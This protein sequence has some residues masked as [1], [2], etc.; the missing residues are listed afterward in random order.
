MTTTWT[1]P[2]LHLVPCTRQEWREVGRWF[3]TLPDEAFDDG[4]PPRLWQHIIT[5][6]FFDTAKPYSLLI[7]I[8]RRRQQDLIG[9]AFLA[10]QSDQYGKASLFL[11]PPF[12]GRGYGTEALQAL[13]K[14]G[15]SILG[16]RGITGEADAENHAALSVMQKAG[17]NLRY[18]LKTEMPDGS[19]RVI[20]GCTV[21]CEPLKFQPT[22]A[23]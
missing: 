19:I 6:R 17:M 18:R 12:R 23:S 1:T 11:A 2:R 3:I 8:R 22:A 10:P 14:Y 21:D 9:A 20:I 5:G 16:L 13:V 15:F 7:A 4:L